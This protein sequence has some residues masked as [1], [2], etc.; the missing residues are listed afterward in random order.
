MRNVLVLG[1]TLEASALALAL[2][3]RGERAVLSYAGRVAQ[4]R[5]QPVAV[6]VGGF[7]GVPGLVQYLRDQ[8]VTHLVDAT[9]PF[10]AQMSAHAI[11]ATAQTGVPLLALTRDP[12]QLGPGDRWQTVADLPAAVATL[13]GPPR[14]VLL[15]LGR[16]HLAAFSAQP[17][18]H[19]I[20]RLVDAP[21]S[22]PPLPQHTVVVSRGPFD[23]AR[24]SALMREHRVDIVVCKNAGGMGAQAKLH[25][26]RLLGLP[27]VMVARPVIPARHE[28]T[29]VDEVLQWMGLASNHGVA[30][31]GTERGV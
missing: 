3:E 30:S 13:S 6:R 12:W 26:A 1:G 2:A 19:Y 5:A 25:A 14:R 4:P 17:Q 23:V 15:A 8:G 27:V 31:G 16:M 18:H 21:D 9:H 22:L 7:G 24:D 29:R 28:V 20:L 11:A 10:A